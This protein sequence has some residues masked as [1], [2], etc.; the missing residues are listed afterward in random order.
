MYLTCGNCGKTN[1]PSGTTNCPACGRSL[2]KASSAL[3]SSSSRP[4]LVDARG[5]QYILNPS[6]AAV[7]GSRGCAILLSDPGV[8]PQA[9]RLTPNS[10]GFII[11]DLCG[12]VEINGARLSKPTALNLGDK[13]KICTSVLVYHGPASVAPPIFKPIVVL[14]P[15][16]S[17]PSISLSPPGIT[18]KSWGSSAPITEGH[19]EFM[20]GPHRV[21]KGSMGAK[22]ATSL[23]LSLISS[24]LMM[25]PFWM[26]Q[27]ITVWFLRVKEHPGGRIISV[28]MRGE[29]G[30]LP[31]LGDFVAIWGQVKD[32]NIIM[33]R[34]YNY[35]T[36]SWIQL[37]G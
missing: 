16:A 34:G 9:A 20:D 27:D 22:V 24:S 28:L 3:V 30:S 26:K 35:A 6:S 14:P 23:A 10:G 17:L 18:L 32:G 8:P 11:E 13:I 7:I 5:R 37:K 21:E 12:A 19:I 2:P 25:L 33:Q 29:P 36:D 31:Q 15:P 4:V 1:I